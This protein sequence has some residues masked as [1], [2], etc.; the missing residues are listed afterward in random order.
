MS[1]HTPRPWSVFDDEIVAERTD[2]HI[3]TVELTDGINP[4]E[5][6]ANMHLIAAAP[7]LLQVA[8]ASWHLCQSLLA[9]PKGGTKDLFREISKAASAAISKAEGAEQP[10]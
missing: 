1:A 3:C 8:R 7:D 10:V 5:W 9:C 2:M 6:Q 4:T